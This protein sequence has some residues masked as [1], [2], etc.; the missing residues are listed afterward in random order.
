MCQPGPMRTR[1]C[2]QAGPIKSIYVCQAGPIRTKRHKCGWFSWRRRTFRLEVTLL[3]RYIT[4]S[5]VASDPEPTELPN[6]LPDQSVINQPTNQPTNQPEHHANMTP[7][8]STSSIHGNAKD[9]H[10]KT[11]VE[12]LS[13]VAPCLRFKFP[14]KDVV[15]KARKIETNVGT[16]RFCKQMLN[17]FF[18]KACDTC[19]EETSESD[20]VAFIT[21]LDVPA[22]AGL[23][24]RLADE[25]PVRVNG[26]TV[27][28]YRMTDHHRG[29]IEKLQN[30]TILDYHV[31]YKTA[32]KILFKQIWIMSYMSVPVVNDI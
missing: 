14:M 13:E 29:V 28:H 4:E 31:G 22:L 26:E 18:N 21:D 3:D 6:Y 16:W 7:H 17:N 20:F 32:M 10:V 9:L 2:I 27:G 25:S 30:M 24:L 5:V 23:A 12:I 19:Q 8:D 11:M 15:K 1:I